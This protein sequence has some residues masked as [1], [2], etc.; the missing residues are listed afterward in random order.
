MNYLKIAAVCM[1]LGLYFKKVTMIRLSKCIAQSG[2]CSRKQACRLIDEG[3][4]FVG[5]IPAEKNEWVCEDEVNAQ[6]NLILVDGKPLN[7][8]NELQYLIYNK[9]VG[10]DCNCNPENPASIINHIKMDQRLYPVGRLDKDSHGLILL[11]NDGDLCHKLMHP[12]YTH[13][14]TYK[15]RVNHVITDEFIDGMSSG[16]E[17]LNTVTLPCEVKK[18]SDYEFEIVLTQGLNRQIRRMCKILRYRVNDLQRVSIL[19]IHLDDLKVGEWREFT[20]IELD[21]LKTSLI[22]KAE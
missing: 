19:N 9:P 8:N 16:I 7:L 13:N 4:V 5:G 22:E 15:V 20:G 2:L 17:M 1:W 3:R 11:T 21:D 14:K 12:Q 18:L 6:E 10:V